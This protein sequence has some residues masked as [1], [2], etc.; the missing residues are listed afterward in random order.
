[1]NRPLFVTRIA[2]IRK[3]LRREF[4][5]RAAAL[6]ITASQFQVLRSLWES[7]GVTTSCLTQDASS[8]G[9]T[10]TG[11]LDRLEN[12]GLI[13]RE[14]STQ[15]RRAVQIWL[16]DEGRALEEPLMEIINEINGLALDGLSE[17]QQTQ[18]L[19]ALDKVRENINA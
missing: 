10:V 16:T 13:R 12:K 1:M 9:G 11:I 4:E 18:L 3:A 14:R 15:D 2:R 5:T 19:K 7:D 8:D 17:R 6:E